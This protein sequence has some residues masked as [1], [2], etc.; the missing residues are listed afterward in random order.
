MCR[1]RGGQRDRGG[2]EGWLG[3]LATA[4][5]KGSG[6]F[7]G[8]SRCLV[9]SR[10]PPK[11]PDPL[12]LHRQSGSLRPGLRGFWLGTFWSRGSF[13][14]QLRRRLERRQRRSCNRCRRLW[15]WNRNSAVG[16]FLGEE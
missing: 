16:R 15:F 12:L 10:P 7:G 8:R 11:T 6:V 4:T 1:A 13:G 3:G 5:P 14:L 2:R 9:E